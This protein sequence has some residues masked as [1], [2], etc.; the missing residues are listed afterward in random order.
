MWTAGDGEA[1]TSEE[2]A[3]KRHTVAD[4]MTRRVVTITEETGYKQIVETLTRK[5]VSAVP[6]VDSELHVLGIVSEADLIHKVDPASLEPHSWL[7]ERRRT[8]DAR[9]KASADFARDLM[10]APALTITEDESVA[11]AARL[12]STERIKR[13]P[14]VDAEGHLIGIVSQSDLLRPY[15]RCDEDI[16]EEINDGALLRT[17]WMDPRGFDVTVKEGVVT[18]HGEI[19][20]RSSVP[21]LVG[22]I[23][24]VPGVVDVIERVSS[25]IDDGR[26]TSVPPRFTVA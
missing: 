14:V 3:M 12:M 26:D 21:I 8:R 16:R 23:R 4:V 20:R 6:V 9:E 11:V 25:R 10:T 18:I 24:G 5:A 15:L 7:L 2:E 19:E 22:I 13:L 17:M 1:R